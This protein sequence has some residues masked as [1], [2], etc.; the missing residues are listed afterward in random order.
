MRITYPFE[1]FIDVFLV[2]EEI[3]EVFLKKRHFLHSLVPPNHKGAVE[4][5][6]NVVQQSIFI[7]ID[8]IVK[9]TGCLRQF[10]KD[11][12]QFVKRNHGFVHLSQQ[13]QRNLLH[14]KKVARN[15][16]EIATFC[17]A[18]SSR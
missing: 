12:A 6:I 16:L 14:S 1:L 17:K 3:G 10:I 2:S 18:C 15:L 11:F 4:L 13:T 5:Q 7:T 9:F 8:F